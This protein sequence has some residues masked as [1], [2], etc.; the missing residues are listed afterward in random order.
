LERSG[1]PGPY[2]NL[3]KVMYSK[4]IAN[5]ILKGEKIEAIPL[6]PG[7]RLGCPLSP[8]LLNVVLK[9]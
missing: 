2:L 6:K 8:H 1:I 5:I 7:T 4:T 9:I 3:I